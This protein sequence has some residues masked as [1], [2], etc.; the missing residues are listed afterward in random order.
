[1]VRGFLKNL[2][3]LAVFTGIFF[4]SSVAFSEGLEIRGDDI[5]MYGKQFFIK[6]VGYSPWRPGFWPGTHKVDINHIKHDMEMIRKAGFN[7]VRTWDAMEEDGLKAAK[8][9]GLFVIQGI[10][11][12][13]KRNFSDSKW[14]EV[15]FRRIREVIEY[16]KNYP[17]VIMYMIMTE[18][19]TRA[20][21]ASGIEETET[22]FKEIVEL[23]HSLDS[24][25]VSMDSWIPAGFLDHSMWDIV[26][27]NA[28]MFTP[29]SINRVLGFKDYLKFIKKNYAY[30]KPLLIGETGGFAVSKNKGGMLGHGG[31]NEDEQARG[32]INSIMY[33]FEA[34]A[35]GSCIVSWID[36]WHY[37]ED[38]NSHDDEPWEWAGIIALEDI[39]NPYGRPRL[40]YEKLKKFNAEYK[41]GDEGIREFPNA[42]KLVI[43]PE[44]KIFAPTE[45]IRV[46]LTATRD[47]KP[48]TYTNI[49]YGFFVQEG[50]KD[51]T[52]EVTTNSK[53]RAIVES[54]LE[55]DNHSGYVIF[56]ASCKDRAYKASGLKFIELEFKE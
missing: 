29:E 43:E 56:T 8:D 32:D 24:R 11:I 55:L 15:Q 44:K 47:G 54:N 4:S 28:F 6:G 34:G 36:T 2:A 13:P 3:V 48:L 17:N 9:N 37:P 27:F 46:N 14:Q 39:N 53:G 51:E 18:P 31:N 22:F 42:I 45:K 1:M 38:P 33:A 20:I 30:D 26:T 23:V 12:D 41:P 7:T 16:S 49:D 5:Y 19:S 40:V 50:W 21:L 25:P 35:V 52:G 10:W